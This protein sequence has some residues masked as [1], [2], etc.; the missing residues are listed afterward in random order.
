MSEPD[1]KSMSSEDFIGHL[2]YT[3]LGGL[4]AD[5]EEDAREAIIDMIRDMKEA[6]A[7]RQLE[8]AV[9]EAARDMAE[10]HTKRLSRELIKISGSETCVCKLC[11]VVNALDK[12][13]AS[14]DGE[15]EV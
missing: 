11:Q 9:I 10:L 12:A 7:P 2:F 13:P 1:I 6:P 5:S 4:Y 14:G 3:V 8:R 15:G